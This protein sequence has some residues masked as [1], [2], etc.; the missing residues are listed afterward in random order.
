MDPVTHPKRVVLFRGEITPCC[1]DWKMPHFVPYMPQV[2]RGITLQITLTEALSSL[3][4]VMGALF[5]V[6]GN[7]VFTWTFLVHF[8]FTWTGELRFVVFFWMMF[9]VWIKVW[10]EKSTT[11]SAMANHDLDYDWLT[12]LCQ[13]WKIDSQFD[14]LFLAP[15]KKNNKAWTQRLKWP[16][17]KVAI[18]F[19]LIFN[20]IV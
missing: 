11:K 5:F 19:K 1:N 15:R 20:K 6:P 13:Y 9:D 4:T 12:I 14:H 16:N 2:V 3:M 18:L 8:E 17:P 10:D 7:F